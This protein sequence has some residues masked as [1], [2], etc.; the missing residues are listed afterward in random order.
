MKRIQAFFACLYIISLISVVL[1]GEIALQSLSKPNVIDP[2]HE[3]PQ[4]NSSDIVSHTPTNSTTSVGLKPGS[5][6]ANLRRK[7]QKDKT[8][9]IPNLK[10]KKKRKKATIKKIKLSKWSYCK[11]FV[12]SVFDPTSLGSIKCVKR[13]SGKRSKKS[14]LG[15]SEI[16]YISI[17]LSLTYCYFYCSEFSAF[18]SGQTFGAVCGPNGCF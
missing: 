10:A 15:R 18:S 12:A 14:A 9:P 3:N 8:T 7:P 11:Y 4:L 6:L 16:S 17:Q 5:V 1:S 13:K 2:S